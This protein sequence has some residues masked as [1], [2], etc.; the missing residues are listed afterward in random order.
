MAIAMT[1]VEGNRNV[2]GDLIGKPEANR[3][4]RR[5]RNK[6]KY[7]IKKDLKE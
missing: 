2:Y 5:S 4:L 7:I 1:L 6:R 3:P